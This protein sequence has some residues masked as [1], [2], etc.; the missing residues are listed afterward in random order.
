MQ[1]MVNGW[2][3]WLLPP[4]LFWSLLLA[5]INLTDL[6]L[7]LNHGTYITEL[8]YFHHAILQVVVRVA[9]CLNLFLIKKIQFYQKLG[10]NFLI[11]IFF[12]E[13]VDWLVENCKWL[14]IT[15]KI[16][17]SPFPEYMQ[18]HLTLIVTYSLVYFANMS[19]AI[20][21]TLDICPIPAANRQ[22][23]VKQ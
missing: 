8:L 12:W 10:A 22:F 4:L 3:S 19:K 1:F 9:L 17:S 11:L 7:T 6:T 2:C 16:C 18:T 21:Q 5:R 23:P 13:G 14:V 15:T 20:V